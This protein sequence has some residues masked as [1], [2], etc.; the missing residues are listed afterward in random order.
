MSTRLVGSMRLV[1]I[2][3]NPVPQGLVASRVTTRDGRILRAAHTHISDARGTV[4]VVC[5]RGDFIERWFETIGDLTARRFAV[6]IFDFRAQGGSS[7]RYRNRSRDGLRSFREYDDD[8]ASVMKQVVLPD[9]PPPYYALGHSTGGLIVL[10][11]VE[12][13]NWFEKA[14]LSAP[15]LGINPGLWPMPVAR[16]LCRFVQSVGLGRC[17]LP[18]QARRPFT[19][20]DFAGNLLTSD[21]HRF[22]RAIATLEAAP[23]LGIAGPTYGW[24]RAAF[25]ALDELDKIKGPGRFRAPVL[26][27]AAGRDRVVDN[28]A[29]RRFSRRTGLPFVV[30]PEARH[31]I[32]LE[33]D[34]IRAQFLAAFDSFIGGDSA[35]DDRERL[36]KEAV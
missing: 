13:R 36:L 34:P 8:L 2:P 1:G 30:I 7:R 26:I 24:L 11:A 33:S 16:F 23:E 10:R 12:H 31:E 22:T 17:V 27:V 6:A 32:L 3:G 9:C 5:G 21:R 19:L 14:V 29:S 15:L 25:A 35:G 18:G 4:V 20:A 28:E